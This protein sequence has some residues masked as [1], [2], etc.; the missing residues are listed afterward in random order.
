[1]KKLKIKPKGKCFFVIV[2][3]EVVNESFFSKR[4][5]LKYLKGVRA[6]GKNSVYINTYE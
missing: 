2:I 5:T 4:I 6:S 3:G 1:M